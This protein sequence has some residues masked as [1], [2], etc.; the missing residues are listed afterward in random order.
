V[1]EAVKAG[2]DRVTDRPQTAERN[3]VFVE[4]VIFSKELPLAMGI[5]LL[6]RWLTNLVA[7]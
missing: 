5:G 6:P 7:C 4:G 1:R 2:D 3:R